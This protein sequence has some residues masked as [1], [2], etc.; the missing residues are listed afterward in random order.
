MEKDRQEKQN[1]RWNEWRETD[2]DNLLKLY[3]RVTNDFA[4]AHF[5]MKDMEDLNEMAMDSSFLLEQIRQ[6]YYLKED[7][8][9]PKIYN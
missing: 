7:N 2:F 5:T 8:L 6:R 9:R 4:V 1:E 3:T